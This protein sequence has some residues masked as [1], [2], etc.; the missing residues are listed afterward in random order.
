MFLE[1]RHEN[2]TRDTVYQHLGFAYASVGRFPE[3]A[4]SYWQALSITTDRATVLGALTGI[5]AQLAGQDCWIPARDGTRRLNVSCSMIHE[6]ICQAY[7]EVA[8]LLD[9]AGQQEFAQQA[10]ERATTEN[11]CAP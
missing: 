4:R 1:A 5:Y 9:D 6:H 11:G 10:R 8:Q 2:P 7:A 3:A